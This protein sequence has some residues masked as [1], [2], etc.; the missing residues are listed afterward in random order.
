[1]QECFAM[2]ELARRRRLLTTEDHAAL[3]ETLE[4]IARMLAGLINGLDKRDG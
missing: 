3:K 4:I 2:L 1:M